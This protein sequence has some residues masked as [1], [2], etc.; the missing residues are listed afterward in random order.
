MGFVPEPPPISSQLNQLSIIYGLWGPAPDL[1]DHL[2]E[3]YEEYQRRY[4][5]NQPTDW[6]MV[7]NY[8][9]LAALI[10]L[11]LAIAW[12]ILSA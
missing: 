10:A 3:T 8:G 9:L 1:I 7:L 11:P 2:P 4:Y 5:S 6:F 12:L